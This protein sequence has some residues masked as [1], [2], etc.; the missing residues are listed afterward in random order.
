MPVPH[1]GSMCKRCNENDTT[2]L[3]NFS[4]SGSSARM[5]KF[6]TLQKLSNKN[7][8]PKSI[9]RPVATR[10]TSIYYC[11]VHNLR[12]WPVLTKF[13]EL[14]VEDFQVNDSQ[15]RNREMS[16]QELCTN[17]KDPMMLLYQLF[18]E[19]ALKQFVDFN[20]KF[21]SEKSLASEKQVLIVKLYNFFFFVYLYEHEFY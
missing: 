2:Y 12:L 5:Q 17:Y 3:R 10:W 18:L 7:A 20:E 1:R 9:L 19:W 15:A 16:P 6:K 21:Q 13:F 4:I 8:T 11:I 14:E